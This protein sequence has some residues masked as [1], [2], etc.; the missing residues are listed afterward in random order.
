MKNIKQIE[1]ELN[2][3]AAL[4]EEQQK[5]KDK[6]N[7]N[8]LKRYRRLQT[9]KA[10]LETQPSA[11]FIMEEKNRVFQLLQK[12]FD[13]YQPLDTESHTKEQCRLALKQFEKEFGV[14]I[15]RT[16]LAT[17]RFLLT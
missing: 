14:P 5:E 7:G 2:E 11:D 10:Y 15:L 13:R 3:V 6:F 8:T 9:C 4:L 16:Q 12:L 17:L 1:A